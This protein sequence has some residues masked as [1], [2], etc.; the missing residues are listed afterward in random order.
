MTR[1]KLK[2]TCL[3]ANFEPR[4]IKDALDNESWVEAMNEEIEQIEKK[5]TQ[6]LSPRP[7]DKN[8]I[9]TIWAFRKN[10][11]KDG[12]VSRNKARLLSKGYSQEEG[13]DY[14]E[15]FNPVVRLEGIRTL[16]A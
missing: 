6:T 16:L 9:S 15:T 13:I 14:G 11:N 10:L 12:K 4:N 5:K 3:L 1:R 8:V 2:G 7:K